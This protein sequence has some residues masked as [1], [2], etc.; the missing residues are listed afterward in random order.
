MRVLRY[1]GPGEDERHLLV[2]AVDDSTQ[3]SLLI[4]EDL[5]H[6]AG[7]DLPRLGAA[8]RMQESPISPREIQVRVRA[9]ES[10]ADIAKQADV[11]LERVMRFATAVVQERIR[12][13]G[14]ARHSRARR[15]SP[16]AELVVFG[17]HVD[18]RFAAHGIEPTSVSWDAYRGENNQWTI[19]AGWHGGDLDRVARWSFIL[20]TRTVTPIDETAADLL[21]DRPIRPV[22]HA[23]DD[24]PSEAM[25]GPI[26]RTGL[27][28]ELFDQDARASRVQGYDS[29]PP[30]PLTVAPAIAVAP[31]SSLTSTDYEPHGYES[32]PYEPHAYEPQA[33]EP[34][35]HEPNAYEPPDYQAP[36]PFTSLR[37]AEPLPGMPEHDEPVPNYESEED[38]AAR[39]HIPSWDDILLGVRR[40]N[41]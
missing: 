17:Q 38:R 2:E 39:A 20:A 23:V 37:L 22:V 7:T 27:G 14:E 24:S 40:K 5:R 18:A 8:A 36:S 31:F 21:S 6:A 1:V 16:D 33:Y 4:T 3:F 30:A 25:T 34:Q 29:T 13:T 28:D 11:P 35:A 41:D 32:A 12:I 10:P 9:G 15:S 19:S 26:P